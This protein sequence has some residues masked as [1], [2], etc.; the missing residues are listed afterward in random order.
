MINRLMLTDVY[1][2]SHGFMKCNVDFE[3]SHIVN[4][5]A[6]MILFGFDAAAHD[7]LDYKVKE[8]DIIQAGA[9]A[10]KMNME[11]P[12]EMFYDAMKYE[13]IGDILKVEALPDGSWVPRGTPFAQISNVVKGFGE[14][15]TWWEPLLLHPWFASSCATRALKMKQY[16]T[17]R[18]ERLTRFHS[19]GFRGHRSMDD[20]YWCGRA[21]SL[22]LPGTDDFHISIDLAGES[23]PALAHKVTMNWDDELKCYVEAVRRSADKGYKA[24]S[25]VIDTVSSKKF[26]E[27]Y[28]LKVQASADACK[29]TPIYRPDSGDVIVQARNIVTKLKENGYINFGIII[30]DSVTFNDAKGYDLVWKKYGHDC[31]LVTWGIG[32]G[33]Y[34]DLTRDSLG[35]AMKTCYSNGKE[36]MKYTDTIAKR[37][38]P[39]KV[40]LKYRRDGK[41]VAHTKTEYSCENSD[42]ILLNIS[43]PST[44]ERTKK[45]ANRQDCDQQEIILSD[46][47][48]TK[49]LSPDSIELRA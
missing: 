5:N 29:I 37:S 4:R 48:R 34:N 10:K 9:C 46:A 24:V 12:A 8:D 25:I 28:L 38:I 14:L 1:N 45:I 2:L 33:F 11:F 19:F 16:L 40:S 13:S 32:A 3:A 39:G 49:M 44:F 17:E 15:V 22:F 6:P 20:A 21:W 47:L 41:L 7:I 35:W 36:R 23:I 42:Y 27:E 26:I 31:N 30:G 18:N 43:T